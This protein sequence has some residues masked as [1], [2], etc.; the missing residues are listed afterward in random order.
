MQFVPRPKPCGLLPETNL[1]G[2]LLKIPSQPYDILPGE[3][4]QTQG[5]PPVYVPLNCAVGLNPKPVE[6][7]TRTLA[8][9]FTRRYE[10]LVGSLEF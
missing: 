8:E 3:P 1:N 4:S 6:S 2:S 9:T 10:A 7:P 5:A